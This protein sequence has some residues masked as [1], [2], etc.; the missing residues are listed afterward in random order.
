[1]VKLETFNDL[2]TFLAIFHFHIVPAMIHY[3]Y[4][5]IKH[6]TFF[7]SNASTS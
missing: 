5:T 1:M 7:D 2:R 3:A 6:T 4:H